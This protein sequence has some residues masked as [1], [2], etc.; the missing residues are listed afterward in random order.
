[1]RIQAAQSNYIDSDANDATGSDIPAGF[2]SETEKQKWWESRQSRILLAIILLLS[3]LAVQLYLSHKTAEIGLRG[4]ALASEAFLVVGITIIFTELRPFRS[5]IE[6]RLYAL[7]RRIDTPVFTRLT[8]VD[9]LRSYFSQEYLLLLR[10]AATKASLPNV[11]QYPDLLRAID[12]CVI[13]KASTPVCRRH[14][15]V[16]LCHEMFSRGPY[17]YLSQTVT[18]SFEYINL[19]ATP[20]IKEI[21]LVVE[22]KSLPGVD[23]DEL[24][25]NAWSSVQHSGESSS[26]PH[27]MTFTKAKKSEAITF[28]SKVIVTIDKEPVT[29]TLSRRTVVSPTDSFTVTFCEPTS[30]L[31]INYQHPKEI[32]PELFCFGVGGATRRHDNGPTW[33]QW[34]YDGVFLPDH[35]IVLVQSLAGER[36]GL[37]EQ[38]S[39]APEMRVG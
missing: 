29:V 14:Y 34:E 32:S 37:M 12:R 13:A 24:L 4:L 10:E 16:A 36:D 27:I 9:Y 8:D 3:G 5:Y 6:E 35:G 11:I 39:Q 19:S 20:V 2:A 31:Q 23:E 38:P 17:T 30:G 26:T 1:M 18:H 28:E 33:T 15:S 25:T 7:K 22:L 21:P